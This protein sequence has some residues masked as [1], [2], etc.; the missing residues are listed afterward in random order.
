LAWC[1]SGGDWGEG[2]LE[3]ER[4]ELLD[5]VAL[6]SLLVDTAFVIVCAEVVVRAVARPRY[7]WYIARF[8]GSVTRAEGRVA[9]M[10]G[11]AKV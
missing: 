2:Y 3:A 8:V 5:E 9:C 6:A 1:C 10:E 4:F 11:R 7:V